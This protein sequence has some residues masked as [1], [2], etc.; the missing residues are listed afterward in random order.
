MYKLVLSFK[1]I[2]FIF[3]VIKMFTEKI[4]QTNVK[5]VVYLL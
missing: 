3:F 2:Y 5:K 1:E 4:I